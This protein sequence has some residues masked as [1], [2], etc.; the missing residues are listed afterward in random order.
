MKNGNSVINR[1]YF[2]GGHLI[3]ALH[4]N[5]DLTRKPTSVHQ[6]ES[7]G[8]SALKPEIILLSD[9]TQWREQL[10]RSVARNNYGIRSADIATVVNQIIF[11]LLFL[12][13]AEERGLIDAGIIKKIHESDDPYT[14][15][16]KISH[17]MD[18]L[19]I[20]P[21][22]D[23][24]HKN[25]LT[26]NPV[27][28]NSLM[29]TILSRLCSAGRPYHFAAIPTEVIAQ[30]F[31]HYLTRT[32]RRSATH[33]AIIVD[34][35]DT[36]QYSGISD[37]TPAMIDFMI[38]ST[39]DAARA[40][41]SHKEILPIRILDP[42][43]SSGF[44][45]LCAFKHLTDAG[46]H[47][48]FAF[49][50]KKEILLSSIYGVDLDRH[51]IAAAKILLVL[52]LSEGE[53]AESLPGDFFT[54]TGEVFR[55][56]RHTLLCG[57]ALI[58]PEIVNEE[59]WTF[60]SP[61]ERHA[62]NLFAWRNSF[63][64]IFAA[65]GFD[66][67][68]G[69]P[70]DEPLESREW[71][72]H[73][74]QRHYEV[75]HPMIDRSAYFIEK[76]LSLLRRNGMLGFIMSERWL[77]GKA[78]S[79]LRSV[80]KMY[81]IEE[82]VYNGEHSKSIKNPAL[83]IIRIAN[84]IPSHTFFVTQISPLFKGQLFDYIR[85]HRYTLDPATLDESSWILRDTRMQDIFCKVQQSGTSLEDYVMG[86][87]IPGIKFRSGEPFVIDESLRKQFIKD[88]PGCKSLI[89]PFVAG[90]GINRYQTSKNPKFLIFIPQGWTNDH[91]SSNFHQWRWFTQLHPSIARH[92][93]LSFEKGQGPIEPGEHWWETLCDEQLW[94]GKHPKIFFPNRFKLPAFM[95]DEGWAIADHTVS[96]IP[97]SNLYLLGLLNSRL[98]LLAFNN[99]IH[100]F[101]TEQKMHTWDDLK[102]LPIYTPDFDN[103][104]DKARHDRM[105]A[106]VTEML[107][108]HKHL[109]DAKTEY[110]KRIVIKEID[111]IDRQIDSLVY[112][113]Y[114]L[115][116]D[117][118]KI[119]EE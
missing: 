76:G 117:E 116:A 38:Q 57:N 65:G 88:D 30:I 41:R 83:C 119:I 26:K 95:F 12:L 15:L 80:V 87:V 105:V 99:F 81:Q 1:K 28:D 91:L 67:V 24:Q 63:P 62:L 17:N 86:Q 34:T 44:I 4:Q 49:T 102:N 70:P 42:A 56:L 69:T 97:S 72:Q 84:C 101:R 61:R 22:H 118:I 100:T 64:E 21:D 104:D 79:S 74:F 16:L 60:C 114:G 32:I 35:R 39:L 54:I 37:P 108:L 19:W 59:S 33:Q 89:R 8:N 9:L 3:T 66:A 13:V 53:R 18:D 27:V 6:V 94:C 98:I 110:E 92:M 43:C 90:T 55:E 107:E 14:E 82:L 58:E 85:S 112:G 23:N 36:L 2:L 111:S 45:L 50:E 73:Y 96:V 113:L 109:S 77:R 31:G 40:T 68:I 71:I 29:K 78:G 20:D 11:R 46:D 51:A 5:R 25:V 115:T 47:A 7:A 106:L 10:A 52:K 75:Y 103:P 93:K 48:F